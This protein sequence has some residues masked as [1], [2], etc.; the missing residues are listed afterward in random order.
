M[1]VVQL[2][3]QPRLQP[4]PAIDRRR[5]QQVPA[6]G[7]AL[8]AAGCAAPASPALQ[9]LR[10]ASGLRSSRQ[11]GARCEAAPACEQRPQRGAGN[12]RPGPAR[13]ASHG[14]RCRRGAAI[15]RTQRHLLLIGA[16]RITGGR[17]SAATCGGRQGPQAC[18]FAVGAALA[19]AARHPTRR[20]RARRAAR[21][22]GDIACSARRACAVVP[23][24]WR[25]SGQLYRQRRRCGRCSPGPT[26][27]EAI[28][29]G[30]AGASTRR[31]GLSAGSAAAMAAAMVQ[32][33]IGK[34][35]PRPAGRRVAA[36]HA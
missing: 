3:S 8:L 14:G 16:R 22:T 4:A 35:G 28:A 15:A 1:A 18:Q 7:V 9:A 2:P 32:A 29:A 13:A 36:Y 20:P 24:G 23:A 26:A 17:S 25:Q 33:R 10:L 31:I 19:P 5:G 27:C 12:P 6:Q 21:W 34:G 11:R 30:T